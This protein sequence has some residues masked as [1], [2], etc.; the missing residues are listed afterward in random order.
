MRILRAAALL[1]GLALFA[2]AAS[3]Q[4]PREG[5][6]NALTAAE[7]AAG[8][9]LLFDGRTTAG[10]RNFKK[11][12]VGPGWRVEDGA[13]VCAD[14]AVAED[15]I[16]AG[17]YGDFDL[18]FQWRIAA[19]GNSGVYYRVIEQGERGYESGPEYQVLDNAHGEP[20]EQQAAALYGLYPPAKDATKPPGQF[21]VG[22]ILVR[23][24]HVEHWL[25]G[26]KVVEYE[27]NSPDFKARVAGSKFA[28][29]PLFATAKTGHI[30]LQ[31]HGAVVAFRDIKIHPLN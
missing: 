16:T 27:L 31:D 15:L 22:R 1:A 28:A 23:Q 3:A 21:N 19:M 13:L 10:W 25:N 24:G 5:A 4:A 12:G 6:H 2:S 26:V 18:S 30:A 11:P 7:K 9:R 8:W 29:W 20:P 17:A 14:P